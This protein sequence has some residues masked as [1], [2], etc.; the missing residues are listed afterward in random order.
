MLDNLSFIGMAGSGKSTLGKALSE[1]LDTSFIDTDQLIEAKFNQ[2]LESLKQVKGYKFVRL[3][4]EAVIL[5]LQNDI[6][7]IS[8]GGSAIYSDRALSH[9]S[10]FS[11]IIYIST[12][13]NTI[14]SRIGIGQERGLA[15]P[16]GASIEDIYLERMPLYE[17]WAQVTLDGTKTVN[18]LVKDIIGDF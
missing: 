7:V 14:K 18:D 17:K 15:A 1:S 5:K 16:D 11:T 13:L 8:T 12:P 10:S 6:K 4:E 9:L 2:S 3:A